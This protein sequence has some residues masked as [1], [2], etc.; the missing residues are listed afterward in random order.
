M[1]VSIPE[2]LKR[3]GGMA[4]FIL[5]YFS[6]VRPLRALYSE[7][8]VY[9]RI[10]T[11][12]YSIGNVTSASHSPREVLITYMSNGTEIVMYHI[13]Q[14]GFFFLCGMLGLIFFKASR[15]AFI[16]LIFF[17]VAIEILVVLLFLLGIHYTVSGFIVS[18]FLMNYLSPLGCLGFVVYVSSRKRNK[19][20]C[21]KL[22]VQ[23]Y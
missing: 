13:P 9:E 14:L 10:F 11:S 16:G 23:D 12:Q 19:F 20:Q 1:K 22:E 5:L 6:T 18:D 4:G 3:V 17:Q 21:S 7:E 2:I 15:R 8:I